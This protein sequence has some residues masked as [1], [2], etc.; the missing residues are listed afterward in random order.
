MVRPRTDSVAIGELGVAVSQTGDLP[1]S[2]YSGHRFDSNVAPLIPRDP[3]DLLALWA[4]CS[5]P[6]Y[7]QA[8]REIDQSL[9]VSNV[10]LTQIPFEVESWR[11]VAAELYPN[12]LPAAYSDDPTQWIFGG[13]IP[14]SVAP[15]HVAVVCLLG[16]R[17]PDQQPNAVDT[18]SD[19]DGVVCIP[20]VRQE[21]PAATRLLRFLET[22]YGSAWSAAKCDELLAAVGCPGKNLEYWLREKFFEQHCALFHDRPFIWHI[23]DDLKKGGFSALVNYHKLDHKLLQTLAYTYLGDW[24][25]TQADG[26]AHHV[27]GASDRLH[28]GQDLQRKLQ[29]ILDGEGTPEAPYDIFV[30]WKPKDEQPIGWNP[31]INDGV[32]LNIRPFMKAG[33][34]RKNPK[35]IEW[36]KDRG[37]DPPDALGGAERDNSRHLT[38]AEKRAARA[39]QGQT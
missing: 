39:A 6:E 26:V 24:I 2:V 27:S 32:R 22:A 33:V 18:F 3:S 14:S 4:F 9:K 8:V 20:A 16:Y 11:L 10:P 29:L 7:S 23:W 31:D 5:S 37:K 38:L 28:A 34:L 21:D 15:L 12:G 35:T 25:K 30:R 19:D 13:V 36:G 1:C 17:W